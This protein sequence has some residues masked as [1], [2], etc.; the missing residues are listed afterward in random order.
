[1]IVFV[2]QSI[3]LRSAMVHCFAFWK[4]IVVTKDPLMN[5]ISGTSVLLI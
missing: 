3:A 4:K 5:D 1:M 2:F